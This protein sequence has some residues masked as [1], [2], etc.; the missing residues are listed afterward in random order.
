MIY[1]TISSLFRKAVRILK[2][3]G[4]MDYDQKKRDR[5]AEIRLYSLRKFF[6]KNANQA[7]F[8]NVEFWMGHTGPGVDAHYRP[9]DPDFYRK[10]YAEK[11]MPF[12]RL[13]SSTP[14]ENEKE[15]EELRSKNAALEEK[16]RQTSQSFEERLANIERIF[17]VNE[18]EQFK[19]VLKAINESGKDR[20]QLSVQSE[21]KKLPPDYY[22]PESIEE[23]RRQREE[24]IRKAKEAETGNEPKED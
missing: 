22:T 24:I 15:I 19:Q 20:V 1:N 14:T 9:K 12:L 17:A 2:E 21:G 23:R 10:I 7:G 16:L 11:A 3:K 8:E 4:E 5:P 18:A 13:E 6:R